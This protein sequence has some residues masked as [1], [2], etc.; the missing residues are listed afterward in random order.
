[1]G[2]KNLPVVVAD[3][4]ERSLS[5]I[6]PIRG[7][8]IPDYFLSGNKVIDISGNSSPVISLEEYLFESTRWG[9]M[10]F[11]RTNKQEFDRFHEHAS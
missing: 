7:K 11:I 4:G 1:M 10:K 2:G 3:L 6:L 8:R 9:S 5:E